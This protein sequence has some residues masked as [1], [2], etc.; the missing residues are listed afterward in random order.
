MNVSE[1][2]HQIVAGSAWKTGGESP[3]ARVLIEGCVQSSAKVQTTCVS[4]FPRHPQVVLGH[5]LDHGGRNT[6]ATA[7]LTAQRRFGTPINRVA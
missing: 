6:L 2:A 1:K 5:E 7:V 3:H 4:M